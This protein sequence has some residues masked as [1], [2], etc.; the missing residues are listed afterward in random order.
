[1]SVSSL[2]AKPVFG[3]FELDAAGTVLY[4]KVEADGI[5]GKPQTSIVGHNFFDV[6]APFGN[7]A[8][9]RSRFNRFIS[10]HNTAENF[11][12]DY[13]AENAGMKAKV[14]LTLVNERELNDRR[15]LIFVDIRK[16]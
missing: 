13:A 14:F 5:F 8:E 10:S 6:V 16:V 12:F 2:Q 1:M 3:C 15:Q 7:S 9:F 4:T 11:I